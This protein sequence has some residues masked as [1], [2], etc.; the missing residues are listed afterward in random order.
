[1]SSAEKAADAGAGARA[2]L[3][4]ASAS[5]RRRE[6][7]K[8][9]VKDFD[10]TPGNIDERMLTGE[11]EKDYVL[12]ISKSKAEA[13]L[14]DVKSYR[15]T[16]AG[17]EPR[18][19]WILAADTIVVIEG[20]IL[21]KPLDADE[22]RRMLGLLEGRAHQVITGVCLLDG[23]GVVRSL[24]AVSSDVWMRPLVEEEIEEYVRS[25]EPFDKAGGY[26]VQ[27]LAGKFIQRVEGSVSNVVGLPLE[28]VGEIL[29]RHGVLDRREGG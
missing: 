12:R 22:A 10:V 2:R 21:G 20:A 29:A 24:E 28:K 18:R 6:L 27:G 17:D 9:I 15:S 5:P 4:L 7:L 23:D 11:D 13:V 26:A 19:L 25:G 14:R 16:G 1:M 8:K 3:I